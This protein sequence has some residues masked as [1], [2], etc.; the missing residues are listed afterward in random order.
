MAIQVLSFFTGAGLL[1]LGMHEAG[2]D[3]VW[4]NEYHLP[5]VQGFKYGFAKMHDA[6]IDD[7]PVCTSSIENLTPYSIRNEAFSGKVWP[8]FFGVIGGPPCPDFSVAGS[9]KGSSGDNGKLTG[10]YFDQIIGLQPTFFVF[11]NVKGILSNL[12]HRKYLTEQ[13]YKISKDY[14]FDIKVMNSL[15]VGVAQDRERV[16]VVGFHKSYLHDVLGITE[17][18]E[19]GLRNRLLLSKQLHPNIYKQHNWFNWPSIYKFENAKTNFEWPTTNAF[20]VK[21]IVCPDNLPP[22]LCVGNYLKGL[23]NI[24]NQN[25]FFTP[26]SSKFLSVE[27]GDVSRKSFKRLHRWRYSPT[28]AY[29]NNEVHLHP[30]L[31]RRLSVREAMRI[32]TIPDNYSLPRE[33]TLSNKF[34][35]IGNG[36]PVKLANHIAQEIY[37][38]FDCPSPKLGS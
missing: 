23:E 8:S 1:D 12:K 19:L 33:M 20:G 29:G 36:V 5:F 35:T 25:E 3:V 31:P 17:L 14:A 22:E 38:F 27:E 28:A 11:E 18:K 21:D 2:F 15:D 9:N 7:F 10:L 37:R 34:K 4:R 30:M 24:E 32:Q 26:K 13:L 6:S 16:I